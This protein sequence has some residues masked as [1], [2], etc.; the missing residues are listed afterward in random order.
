MWLTFRVGFGERFWFYVFKLF[1]S[2]NMIHE[3]KFRKKSGIWADD[4]FLFCDEKNMSKFRKAEKLNWQ[5]S[6]VEKTRLYG[7]ALD[8]PDFAI[9]DFVE[10]ATTREKGNGGKPKSGDRI[11]FNLISY[12]YD[13]FIF[14]QKILR[15]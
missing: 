13:A 15:K 12:G 6:L 10:L 1:F 7:E 2:K 8:Y 4:M 3:R 9:E 14:V 11:A 5:E